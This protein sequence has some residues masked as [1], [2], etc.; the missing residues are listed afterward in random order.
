[1]R[2]FLIILFSI[3]CLDAMAYG[4]WIFGNNGT[5]VQVPFAQ[6]A[7]I[8]SD[9]TSASSAAL[10]VAGQRNYVQ[11]I[12]GTNLHLS[13]ADAAS[14]IF[15]FDTY[16]S[17]GNALI[18]RQANGTQ[19]SPTFSNSNL[20]VI[21]FRGYGSTGYSSG[22]RATIVSAA[23]ENWTDSAQGADLRFS[24]TTT[25]TTTTAERLRIRNNGN[26]GIGNI[27][28]ESRLTVSAQSG[29]ATP[30]SGTNLHVSGADAT[31]NIFELDSYGAVTTLLFRQANGTQTSP[32]ASSSSSSLGAISWRGYGST[33]YSSGTRTQI[34]SVPTE[35]WTDTAQG[36]DLRFLTT[37]TGASSSSVRLYVD[38]EG[39][40]GIGTGIN[41]N[42]SSILELSSTTKGF[43][44]P[45]MSL[46]QQAAISSP[47]QGLEVY[48]TTTNQKEIYNGSYWDVGSL[49]GGL[50][51]LRPSLL[52]DFANSRTLDPRIT[53][54]RSTTATFVNSRG[55][56]ETAQ[57]NQPRFDHDPTTLESL[58]LLIEEAR[59]NLALHS[60][61]FTN[62]AWV[63]TNSF[64][65]TNAAV[66]PDG[67][68]TA[69]RLI[70]NNA[71]VFNASNISQTISKAASAITYT[72]SVFAKEDA[73]DRIRLSP[74]DATNSANNVTVIYSLIDGSVVSA[75][76]ASGTFT[77]A[78]SSV[79]AYSNGWYRVSVTFTT[80]TETSINNII[81]AYDSV[82][83]QGDGT[84]G[85]FIWGA[86]LEVGAFPTSYIP[87]VASSVNRAA[88]S[89]SMTGTNFSSWFNALE[90]TLAVNFIRNG[91]DD[92]DFMSPASISD[93][94][95]NN[96]ITFT[97]G[98]GPSF[99]FRFDVVVG[100]VAQ[101]SLVLV[102]PSA[103]NTRYKAIGS[104]K[105]NDF[106]GTANGVSVQ[107]DNSGT[108]PVVDR[109]FIGANR[110]GI[111]QLNGAISSLYFY[112]KRL[113]NTEL[114][115][116][117]R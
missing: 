13:G 108:I 71:T 88:D 55:L 113:T 106:A 69:D 94:T 47:A 83:S 110:T 115:A 70:P 74:R 57:I 84:S 52:L 48:D 16:G 59:T 34:V 43:L 97:H 39:D 99:P 86:Q 22:S 104:Y 68:T 82:A 96:T 49:N 50:P 19:A 112:P 76:A 11:P 23:V 27:T 5:S 81:Y 26:V 36:T 62:A 18:F 63:N 80:G 87:T 89:A 24:T 9:Q 58:G 109:L 103:I 14:N 64:E 21:G 98:S 1:M 56:I 66:S 44:P 111:A 114:Q 79:R 92:N 85:I 38:G 91:S 28:A 42:A 61:D 32:T 95:N 75:V 117:S 31:A 33:A 10:T 93:N 101:A 54:T 107:T 72:F 116:V 2:N 60:E 77:N 41:S 4:P 6:K 8:G 30:I 40:V 35:T 65:T 12:S 15:L 17:G 29:V 20:G 53:F 3:L 51:A 102:N 67:A 78:S 100:G 37:S 25:G 45:R 105:L 90:G 73:F 7:L 46:A